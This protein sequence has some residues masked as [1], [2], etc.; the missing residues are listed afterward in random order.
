MGWAARVKQQRPNPKPE[1]LPHP[2]LVVNGQITEEGE[3]RYA[4]SEGGRRVAG[5]PRYYRQV[6]RKLAPRP[7]KGHAGS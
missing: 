4:L 6:R 2:Y 3:K 5:E 1:A 7:R